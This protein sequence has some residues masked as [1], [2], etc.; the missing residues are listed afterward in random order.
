MKKPTVRGLVFSQSLIV[1]YSILDLL[2]IA[3]PPIFPNT[4][5]CFLNEIFFLRGGVYERL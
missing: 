4:K 2:K 5:H 3:N 1:A